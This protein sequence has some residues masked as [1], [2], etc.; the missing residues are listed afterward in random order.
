MFN[1]M[2]LLVFVFMFVSIFNSAHTIAA[3]DDSHAGDIQPW[4]VGAEIFVNS[5]LFEADFGD[6]SG[7]P[8][9]TDDPGVDVNIT[10]GAFT[11]GN[12]L[13][14]QPVG[15]LLYWNGAQWSETIPNG[16]RIDVTDALN[17][18]ISFSGSGVSETAGVIGEFGSGGDLHE[19]LS[20]K[21]LDAANTPNGTAGAYRIQFKL[22]E[23]KANNDTSVSVASAPIAIV[24]NRGLT[25]ESFETAVAA[26][27]DL[28][29]N[30][31]FSDGNGVLTIQ[32]VKALGTRYQV[33]LQHLGGDKFQLIE[34]KQIS[35]AE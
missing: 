21:M 25:N 4:R 5:R 28:S 6:L 11:S 14:F 8:F 1:K 7:G 24:F 16:E 20:F 35:A 27:G 22:F 15:K 12:W 30:A 3:A 19:H 32:S 17:R 23:S 13:R 18:V 31:V 33:K 34:A 29:E 26:A 9:E 10:K 2:K